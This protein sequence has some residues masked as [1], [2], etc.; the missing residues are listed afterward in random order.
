M[1]S[2]IQLHI[3]PAQIAKVKRGQPIQI[4]HHAIG[5]AQGHTFRHLHPET[6]KKITKAY[7]ARKGVRVQFTPAE[8]EGTGFMDFI[9][10]A[11][12]FIVKNKNVLKPLATAVL[13]TGAQFIPGAAPYREGIRKF[14][15]VGIKPRKAPVR[16]KRAT[17][18]KSSMNGRGVIPAGYAGF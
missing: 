4:P 16:R 8:L 1:S 17:V 15:G 13:D 12:E 18:P 5:H 10:K 2:A 9:K 14:T 3:S 11:G 6:H 7:R